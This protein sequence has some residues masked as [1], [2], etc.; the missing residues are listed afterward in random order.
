MRTARFCG[1]WGIDTL[2]PYLDTLPPGKIWD[3]RYPNPPKK[4]HGTRYPT[5]THV[6]TPLKTLPSYNYCCGR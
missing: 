5:P 1:F 2:S 4:E 6:H 3:Q